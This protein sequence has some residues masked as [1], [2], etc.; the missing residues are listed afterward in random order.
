MAAIPSGFRR[1]FW[2]R[3]VL[4]A[5]VVAGLAVVV[6]LATSLALLARVPEELA[7]RV[8]RPSGGGGTLIVCGGG[9]LPDV[10]RDRFV[11]LAG[12]RQA[13]VVVIPTAGEWAD[14]PGGAHAADPWRER[15]VASA[16]VLHTL[17]RRLANDPAFVRP[18]TVAT[19]VWIGGGHQSRL[20]QAYADT[21]VER[22]LK[23]LLARGGVI[24][25]TSAGAGVMSRVMIVK[26]RD[27]AEVGRGLDLFPDV[28][29]DQ[30]FLKRN[31]IRRLLGVLAA[32][33]HLI[34]LGI[35]EQTALEVDLRPRRVRVIG[36]SYAIACVPV[37]EGPQTFPHI[38]ILKP[39]DEAD[40]ARIRERMSA[41]V[42]TGIEVEGL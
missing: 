15:G 31:R 37:A 5:V 38:E 1:S 21:A 13:R 35:D 29:I 22:E 9:R 30:H 33:R 39:G 28:V 8:E 32:N 18:L 7:G 6:L 3:Q 20:S 16:T 4:Y 25:G 10:V 24:G 27:Q 12:G 14:G 23:A 40:L 2:A 11:E 26:G 19:G 36:Q 41:A 17:D 42:T 34:G